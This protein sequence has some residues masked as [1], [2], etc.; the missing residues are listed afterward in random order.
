MRNV[1]VAILMISF[2]FV[3]GCAKPNEASDSSD[4]NVIPNKS[5]TQVQIDSNANEIDAT[6]SNT[7]VD[8]QSE[9]NSFFNSDILQLNYKGI[10]L[11]DDTLEKDVTL[12]VNEITS[13]KDGKVYE[14]K[15]DPIDGIPNERLCLGY[16]YVQK[17]KIYKMEP[18]EENLN[19]LKVSGELPDNS[20]I[21]CQDKVIKD[22]L[23]EGESGY[24]HYLEISGD[25][26]EFHSYNNQVSTG[27]FET[28]I[29]EK[30]KGMISYK[31]G[32]GADR[33]S[34]ELLLSSKNIE[35]R[36]EIN[37][38]TSESYNTCIIKRD[39]IKIGQNIAG[40]TVK[41]IEK[42]QNSI[43]DLTFS[44]EI[45]LTG[46]Y[47]WGETGDGN[48]CIFILDNNSK[49]KLPVLEAIGEI[50]SIGINNSDVAENFYL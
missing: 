4:K 1:I 39:S 7:I 17:D 47:E 37:M 24:H 32:Y 44:G 43:A 11:F 35:G 40:L 12:R 34:I 13:L 31:S 19:K 6:T 41:S 18:T 49:S 21:V 50:S 36:G 8:E 15:L 10:F 48:G 42:N 22:E 16:F 30:N 29:W 28:I 5:N 14:F 33:D 20:V 2:L 38:N 46:T 26:R 25:T 27:Y 9:A 23:G 45:T 3:S